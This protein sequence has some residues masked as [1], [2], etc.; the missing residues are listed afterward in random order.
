MPETMW[1]VPGHPEER[2]IVCRYHP[3]L[4][5]WRLV[6][7]GPHGLEVDMGTIE[8]VPLPCDPSRGQGPAWMIEVTDHAHIRRW[9]M[10][11][12]ELQPILDSLRLSA[13]RAEAENVE[14]DL[15][16]EDEIERWTPEVLE[17]SRAML[18]YIQEQIR[19]VSAPT[20]Q[21]IPADMRMPLIPG[22]AL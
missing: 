13:L 22:G 6:L 17:R 10:D 20:P 12:D 3:R 19:P 16:D 14:A 2:T 8:F 9:T 4:G 5:D 21:P 18:A 7:H 1:T 15:S 11:G